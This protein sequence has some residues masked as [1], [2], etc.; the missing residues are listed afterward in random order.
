MVIDSLLVELNNGGFFTQGYSDD[1]SCLI[2]GDFLV[3]IGDLMRTAMGIVERWCLKNGL[4]IN[5]VK[6]KLVLFSRRRNDDV[7]SL[8]D[9]V[10]FGK[11]VTLRAMVKYLG[12][13]FDNKLTWILHLMDKLDKAIGIFWMC[14]NAF[15]RKWG[16]TPKA[17]WWIYTAVVRPTL[18]H[19]CIVWW[20]R[21]NVLTAE[22]ALNKL[23]RLACLC[24]TGVKN[25][26]STMAL[27]ALLNLPPLKLYV[28]SVAF[29]ACV[30]V[31]SN[32]WWVSSG[33]GGHMKIMDL[34]EDEIF[35]MPSDQMR[36]EL[37]L[38][39]DFV[40]VIPERDEWL[41]EGSIFPPAA[42]I[43]CYTDGSKRDVLS[44]SGIFCESPQIEVSLSTGEYATVYQTELLAIS[45]ICKSDSICDLFGKDI[46]ICT[47]SE[48]AI[49]AVSSPLVTSRSV[50]ECK[51]NLN[52]LGKRNKV[53]LMWV[54]SH[55]GIPG[56]EKADAL[57]G[58]GAENRFI[59]PEPFLGISK[60]TRK[61]F[62]KEWLR[63]EHSIIWTNYAG[64]RHTKV[65]FKTPSRVF[66]HNL[67]NLSRTNIKRV[68]EVI[69]NHCSLN[70]H[71][72]DIN[73]IDNP[74]CLCGL[75]DE[76]GFHIISNCPRYRRFRLLL[77]DKPE[78]TA[79]DLSI[80][81]LDLDLLVDFL[82]RTNRFT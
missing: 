81:T 37:M 64:A 49:K 60:T 13:T 24:V 46:Y 56:N 74:K 8:G 77:F 6:T 70:K 21:V 62:V 82:K 57:A 42:G 58:S 14:R 65:F 75:D 45:R 63:N 44:G 16:L 36:G 32:G 11:A 12:V 55:Q 79:P 35:K 40:G 50:W 22:K 18:C 30:N 73:C 54:P 78:L 61:N 67:L 5:P 43:V 20:P 28:K 41:G 53:T 39:D 69:T 27:E 66:S 10:I 2:C 23:Q 7:V 9:F 52:D 72:H 71:L 80:H 3:T 25:T 34:I 51:T 15:G 47:D 17:I 48:S 1:V 38:E 19:G 59:G 31:Q 76:T 68:I 4:I 26:T 29:W 33:S